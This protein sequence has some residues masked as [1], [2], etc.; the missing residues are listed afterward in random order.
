MVLLA[1]ASNVKLEYLRKACKNIKGLSRYF[2]GFLHRYV[3]G[4]N[5]TNL[6]FFALR[7]RIKFPNR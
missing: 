1:I 3:L 4:S 6:E 5:Q 7:Y 2:N